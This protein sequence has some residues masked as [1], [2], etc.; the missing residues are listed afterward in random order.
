MPPMD[1]AREG[2][3]RLSGFFFDTL[4]LARTFT[5]VG[6]KREDFPIMAKKSCGGAVLK[7]FKHLQQ[8]DIEKI[9]EMCM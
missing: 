4:G 9:F 3:R 6:I 7:G 2:I 5:E 8:D 1:I